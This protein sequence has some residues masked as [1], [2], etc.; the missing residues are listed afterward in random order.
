[1][2]VSKERIYREYIRVSTSHLAD[3][4]RVAAVAKNLGIDP[5]Q[6]VETVLEAQAS[7]VA[8]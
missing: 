2:I 8:A 5:G 7:E 4:H 3:V 1:M 6:V